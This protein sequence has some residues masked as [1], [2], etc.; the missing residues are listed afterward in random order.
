M[1]RLKLSAL[2]FVGFHNY[3]NISLQV[4]GDVFLIGANESGKT[5]VLDAI[6]LVLSSGDN[7][8]WNAGA[9]PV[10]RRDEGRS[11]KGVILRS[12]LAGNP[13][14]SCGIAW[15]ALEF[16]P[17]GDPNA[18]PTT[19]LFGASVKTTDSQVQRFGSKVR[20]SLKELSLTETDQQGRQRVLRREEV[21]EHHG[22]EISHHIGH[23]RRELEDFFGGPQ[24]FEQVTKLWQLAK[25]YKDLA[26]RTRRLSD[27]FLEFLPPPNPEAFQL[28][29]K[30]L[31]DAR[32]IESKLAE[33]TVGRDHLRNLARILDER[34]NEEETVY[35]LQYILAQRDR[36]TTN[37]QIEECRNWLG[38]EE[39]DLQS[40]Q[41]Q[42]NLLNQQIKVHEQE[43]ETLRSSEAMGLLE[44]R[45]LSKEA[46]LR[47]K[48]LA[49]EQE[50]HTLNIRER[51]LQQANSSEKLR[52]QLQ[53]L[54]T[55]LRTTVEINTPPLASEEYVS[56]LLQSLV[57]ALADALAV[58]LL[59]TMH[60]FQP[61]TGKQLHEGLNE[62]SLKLQSAFRE[63]DE[64]L[65]ILAVEEEKVIHELNQLERFA[66]ELPE[67]E[68]YPDLL[69][70]LQ[71]AGLEAVPF[72][73]FLEP[74][75]GTQESTV[76]L[77]EQFVGLDFLSTLVPPPEQ[78]SQVRALVQKQA[79]AIRV[80]DAEV[81]SNEKPPAFLQIE[82]PRVAA[83]VGALWHQLSFSDSEPMEGTNAMTITGDGIAY[84]EGARSRLLESNARFIGTA[85]RARHRDSKKAQLQQHRINLTQ[86][87]SEC[88]KQRTVLEAQSHA[89][90]TLLQLF[91]GHGEFYQLSRDIKSH[92]DMVADLERLRDTL[93]EEEQRLQQ[94][95]LQYQRTA[96]QLRLLEEQLKSAHAEGLMLRL[97]EL[98]RE[99]SRL[100]QKLA[101]LNESQIVSRERISQRQE[102]LAGLLQ[103]Q[104]LQTD[105]LIQV[106]EEL[107]A[108]LDPVP[109]NLDDYVY[110]TK[111]GQR[112]DPT[113]LSSRIQTAKEQVVRLEERLRGA[114]GMMHPA[115]V[116]AYR[117]RVQEGPRERI[118][119]HDNK[120]L[121]EVLDARELDVQEWADR[122]TQR[123]REVFESLLE[124]E[125]IKRLVEDRRLLHNQLDR[126]NR[127]LENLS[128]NGN[129]YRIHRSVKPESQWL[130]ANLKEQSILAESARQQLRMSLE[131][132]PELLTGS[133]ESV[134]E[135]LDY[136]HWY[137][138]DFKVLRSG[139]QEAQAADLSRG[140]GGA[141]ANYNYLLLFCL[142]ANFFD[143]SES[144]IRLLVM[145]EAFH[146]L[147]DD[148]KQRLLLAAKMLDLDLVI[149]TPNVDGTVL[150]EE[151][152]TTTILVE[153]DSE[154]N[155]TLI[156]LILERRED[157]LFAEPRQEPILRSES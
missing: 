81:A 96:L 39:A 37:Q 52:Q 15:A 113:T 124:K 59:P 155:V 35:R 93:Q 55:R 109:I 136:R 157:D 152:D 66:E 78:L 43:R 138:Y 20:L 70:A 57:D 97:Q 75:M 110:R 13:K 86:N 3:Q 72:Y 69:A 68:G 151:Y 63:S 135:A 112:G 122:R 80:L 154:D 58:N 144:Q 10:G 143:E 95:M 36:D 145:D 118:L 51:V 5:T 32:E 54:T 53:Q 115:L 98:D 89:C 123:L 85:T 23:Y 67:I 106:R 100:H 38:K 79:P 2:R 19:F 88:L 34:N 126:L 90:K 16:R 42:H 61:E 62:L 27:L 73:R 128:F 104:Q 148:R 64:R 9:N 44:R 50:R 25:S 71:D 28:V 8:V 14:L 105:K 17:E 120:T 33:L 40:R 94:S 49:E 132:R 125:L 134:P 29:R 116:T 101:T 11:L 6:Q 153:K 146:N 22:V 107:L 30:G 114:D 140:S 150:G 141:Q 4:K 77:L 87:R 103:R 156:P 129:Q 56:P 47:E 121:S 60:T 130:E 142:A 46:E 82:N 1:K 84:R 7:F 48:Q 119:T 133:Q 91:Q 92:G 76:A 108:F 147:D 117:F 74:S 131:N 139:Q 45:N 26:L 24:R 41:E 18:Q 111:Q 83:H 12:D 127:R 99:L 102:Q 149:A 137:E 21:A 31:Q 65:A